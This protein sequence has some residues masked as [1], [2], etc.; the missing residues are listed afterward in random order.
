M[1]KSKDI[2][3]YTG[4][5][6]KKLKA[7]QL[8]FAGHTY[9][10]LATATGYSIWTL[11]KYFAEG[12]KWH[13]EYKAWAKDRL[14]DINDQLSGM[15]TAQAI[16]AMQRIVNLSRGHATILVVD[17]S[18]QPDENGQKKKTRIPI[19]VSDRTMLEASRDILDRAGFKPPERI[20]FDNDAEDEAEDI[21]QTM[22]K[23]KM[24]EQT[25]EPVTN[26]K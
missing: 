9:E 16:E 13:E 4:R 20:K 5:E 3:P 1:G 25:A 7:F 15:F 17:E 18:S 8:R 23:M 11:Q 22:E 19:K 6:S 26:E 14:D 2:K 10:E 21:L 24:Q 12:G